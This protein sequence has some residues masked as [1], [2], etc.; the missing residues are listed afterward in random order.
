MDADNWTREQ[1]LSLH[2]NDHRAAFGKYLRGDR[3]VRDKHDFL[4]SWIAPTEKDVILECG[5]SSGKTCIDLARRGRCRAVGVD[6]DPEAVEVATEMRDRHFPELTGRCRFLLG[7]LATMAFSSEITKVVMPDFTE[8]IPDSVFDAILANIRRQLPHVLLYIYTP[9]RTHFFER[10][11][12]H[13][14]I[15]KNPS[16]HINV[17]TEAEL[18]QHLLERGW[19][20][21]RQTWRPSHLPVLR[22]AERLLGRLPLIGPMC[23]RRIAVLAAPLS[24]RRAAPAVAAPRAAEP[25]AAVAVTAG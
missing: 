5:S 9:A 1:L 10:M 19:R 18:A 14:F 23:H 7:D 11:R 16:G 3:H 13:N 21:V 4:L 2:H 17:K 12:R 22:L 15:L 20:I 24:Q 6:F 8:H 25:I